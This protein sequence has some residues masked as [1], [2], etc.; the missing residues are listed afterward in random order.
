LYEDI[1]I[2]RNKRRR[3]FLH[4]DYNKLIYYTDLARNILKRLNKQIGEEIF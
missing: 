3:L 2:I 1:L 4:A